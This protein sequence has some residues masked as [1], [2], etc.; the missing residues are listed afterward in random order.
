MTVLRAFVGHSFT[1]DDQPVV[2]TF[3]KYL[4]QL[5]R[6][7]LSFS[8][9]HAEPAEPKLLADKVLALMA[10]KNVFVAIC[11]KKERVI[12]ASRLKVGGLFSRFLKG[13]PDDFEWKTSDWM[14]QEIGLARGKNLYLILL[15]ENG[16]RAPGGL[17]GDVGY[18][19]FDRE[20]PERSYPPPAPPHPRK[21]CSAVLRLALVPPRRQ[22]H[23]ARSPVVEN[24]EVADQPFARLQ[25]A[26]S[27][28]LQARRRI[29]AT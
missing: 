28:E 17:Q 22:V 2:G 27:A 19:Q 3:L 20:P 16:L 23:R 9:Q 26:A 24:P 12:S 1:E 10:D 6:S 29:P 7:S 15:I 14:I 8:W 4:D 21:P 11:T 18:I 13:R 5:S 25:A